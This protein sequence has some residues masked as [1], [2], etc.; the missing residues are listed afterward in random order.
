MEFTV[1]MLR[2]DYWLTFTRSVVVRL[3]SRSLC[4]VMTVG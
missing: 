1:V 2:Y 3:S 4:N